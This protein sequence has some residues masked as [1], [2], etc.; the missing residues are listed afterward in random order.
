[1]SG[2][3]RR[4]WCL[5]SGL[6]A[7]GLGLPGLAMAGTGLDRLAKL[8][9]ESGGRLGVAYL[10]TGTGRRGGFRSEERFP[11]CSTFKFLLAGAVFRRVDEGKEQLGRVVR[12]GKADLLSYAPVAAAKVESGMSVAELCAAA[13]SLSDNTAANLLLASVGGPAAV[14][15]FVRAL[16]DTVTRLDRNEPELNTSIP[17]DPRDTTTPTEVIRDMRALVLGKALSE[18]SKKLLTEWLVG[19]KTGDK[20]IRAGMPAGATV[21]DK[22]G[23]GGDATGTVNDVAVVWPAGGRA[24]WLISVYLTRATVAVERREGILAEAGR[25]VA[26]RLV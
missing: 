10:D 17:G 9:E 19:C 26:G 24:P 20:R 2:M 6:V 3:T 25:L 8:E 18:E 21:G 22:T 13:V 15:A 7:A 5:R 16:G 1:M 4:E 12:Y 23:T 11:M 14:T